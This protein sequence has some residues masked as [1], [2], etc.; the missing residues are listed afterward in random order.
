MNDAYPNITGTSPDWRTLA[1]VAAFGAAIALLVTAGYFAG[2]MRAAPIGADVTD[3]ESQ[4]RSILIAQLHEIR[5]IADAMERPV[6][7][8]PPKAVQR[9]K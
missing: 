1:K 9:G 8:T 5:R 4:M 3:H 6:H 2:R 7:A